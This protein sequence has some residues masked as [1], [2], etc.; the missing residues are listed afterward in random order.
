[1][2]QNYSRLASVEERRNRK[3]AVRLVVLTVAVSVLLVFFGIPA[4]SKLAGFVSELGKSDKPILKGDMTPPAPPQIEQ[5]PEFTNFEKITL[6]GK[7]E[8]GATIKLEINSQSKEILTDSSGAFSAEITLKKGENTISATSVD[9]SGNSS[10][11]S[12]GFTV[13]FDDEEP[14]IIIESP[15]DRSTIYGQKNSQVEI[16]GKTEEGASVTINGKFVKV[17][18]GGSFTYRDTLGE[19]ENKFNIK[20][21]DRAGNF[22]EKDFFVNFSL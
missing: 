4:L 2:A 7:T 11:K 13:V 3:T 19:G 12:K 16:K 5:L 10:L 20:S 6:K 18:S 15:E 14:E 1:M 22:T 21:L 17:E 9:S 8:A